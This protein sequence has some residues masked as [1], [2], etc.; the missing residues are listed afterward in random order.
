M[1]NYKEA[2]DHLNKALE[3]H[4]SLDDRVGMAADS[5]NIG[6]V[7]YNKDNTDEALDYHKKA[8]DSYRAE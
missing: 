7:F 8:L 6:L 1:G 4:T 2:L 5:N 3:I